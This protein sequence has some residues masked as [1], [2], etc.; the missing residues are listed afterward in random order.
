MEA[1]AGASPVLI[2]S[3]SKVAAGP[4]RDTYRLDLVTDVFIAVAPRHP[5]LRLELFLAREPGGRRAR[6]YLNDLRSRLD[7]AHLTGRVSIHVGAPLAEAFQPRSVYLRP[8]RTDGDAVSIR[9][10]LHRGAPV[11]ASDAASRPGGVHTL[12]G[13]DRDAWVR[14]CERFLLEPQA[15]ATVEGRPSKAL[16]DIYR[17]VLAARPEHTEPLPPVS[18]LG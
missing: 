11:I 15:V 9:E 7:R 12:P 17:R 3:A 5:D 13:D 10:A 18:K 6:A 4:A 16:L 1:P 2:A 8:T 14:A